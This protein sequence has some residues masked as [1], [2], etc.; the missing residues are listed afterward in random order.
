LG[1]S[2]L[3][4]VSSLSRW[5]EEHTDALLKAQDQFAAAAGG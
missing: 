3:E 2:L 4:P 1:R 5:A